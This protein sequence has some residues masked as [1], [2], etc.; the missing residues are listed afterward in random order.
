MKAAGMSLIFISLSGVT[1]TVM[2]QLAA[3]G[4]LKTVPTGIMVAGTRNGASGKT[5]C[6]GNIVAVG[7]RI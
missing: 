5:A 3:S 1:G 6:A 7:R 2:E 4:G